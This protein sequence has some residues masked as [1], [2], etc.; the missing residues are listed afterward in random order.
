MTFVGPLTAIE[1]VKHPLYFAKNCAA[2]TFDDRGHVAVNST[3]DWFGL[4]S[5]CDIGPTGQ[6]NREVLPGRAP[7]GFEPLCVLEKTTIT[8][9]ITRSPTSICALRIGCRLREESSYEDS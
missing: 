3:G 2:A 9:N 6:P 5:C 1:Y 7:D 8:T 4:N